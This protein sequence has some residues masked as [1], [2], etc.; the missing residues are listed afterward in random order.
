VDSG[1]FRQKRPCPAP[2]VRRSLPAASCNATRDDGF[3][4]G[5]ADDFVDLNVPL[6]VPAIAGLVCERNP[7]VVSCGNFS[8]GRVR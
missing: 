7:D 5:S 2:S 4:D 6:L 1:W 3:E 8:I